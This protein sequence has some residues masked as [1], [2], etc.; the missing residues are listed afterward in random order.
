MTTLDFDAAYRRI[1]DVTGVTRQIDLAELFGIR[2]SSI[3]DAKRRGS[4]PERWLVALL[5]K[6]GVSPEWILTGQGPRYIAPTDA[7]P[8]VVSV[9]K[10]IGDFATVDLLAELSRRL[11]TCEVSI[12]DKRHSAVPADM[13]VTQQMRGGYRHVTG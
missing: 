3:S 10:G 8:L 12:T 13:V 5:R 9:S 7:A 4:I 2:Q 11:P 6:Q 1:M